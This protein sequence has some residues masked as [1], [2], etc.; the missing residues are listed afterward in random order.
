MANRKQY[1]SVSELVRDMAPDP[2]FRAAFD[3]RV[4]RRKLVKE[5]LAMRAVRGLSQQDIAQKLDC[6]QSRISK[7]ENTSD[8]DIRVGDLR[9]YA[10]AVGCE[11]AVCPIPRDMKPV[12]KVK[13]HAFAIKTHMDDLARL[14]RSDEKIAEGVGGF[15]FEL[16]VNFFRLLGDSEKLLPKRPNDLP[17]F[18][19]QI[20]HLGQQQKDSHEVCCVEVGS[21]PQLAR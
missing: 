11:L 5:L 21:P 7:L 20:N 16:C 10:E 2:E 3:G 1:T 8:D 18:D 6:T 17:Y 14:A 4:A 15:F 9:A 19:L 12:D 13:C